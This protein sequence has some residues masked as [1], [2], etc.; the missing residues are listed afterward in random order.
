[1]PKSVELTRIFFVDQLIDPPM[2]MAEEPDTTTAETLK[3][4]AELAAGEL[5]AASPQVNGNEEKAE[6]V[7]SNPDGVTA[8]DIVSGG[9]TEDVE[10]AIDNEPEAPTTTTETAATTVEEATP[11]E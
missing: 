10:M 6:E 1:M 8:Y 2:M 4:L 7:E 5:E 9:A 11:G 3:N